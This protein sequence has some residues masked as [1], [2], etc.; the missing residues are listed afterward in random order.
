MSPSP[1]AVRGWYPDPEDPSRLLYWDGHRWAKQRAGLPDIDGL[2]PRP[3]TYVA[4]ILALLVVA[5]SIPLYLS[6]YDGEPGTDPASM[7][8]FTL[9]LWAPLV[10]GVSFFLAFRSRRKE[11][12]RRSRAGRAWSTIGYWV[13]VVALVVWLLPACAMVGAGL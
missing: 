2:R 9:W 7:P 3:T 6:P 11:R 4:I 12:E 5:M 13:A 8:G 10:A 1:K